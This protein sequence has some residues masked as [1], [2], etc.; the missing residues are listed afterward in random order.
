M[1]GASVLADCWQRIAELGARPEARQIRPLF[2][3]DPDRARRFSATVDDLTLD[4]SKTSIDSPTL[5]AAAEFG[6]RPDRVFGFRDWVGGRYS[7][8][9]PIGLSIAL[10]AGWEA[11]QGMLDGGRAM[12]L[13]FQSADFA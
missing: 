10:A 3:A 11:F 2:A 8:W 7:L 4:F 12:D 9:S 1:N 13:H 6:I 5:A